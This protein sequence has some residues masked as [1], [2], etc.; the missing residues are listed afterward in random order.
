MT[1]MGRMK[2][3]EDEGVGAVVFDLDDTLYPERDFAFSGYDAVESWL[4]AETG[5]QGFAG[6]CRSVFEAGER[7]R[8][9]NRALALAGL[10]DDPGLIARMVDVYR[11][12][13]PRIRLAA[14]AA[15]WLARSA[16]P[17]GL[18]TD[19][20]PAMQRAKVRALGI[21]DRLRFAIFT[22]DWPQG[23]G[24]PHCRPFVEAERH[25]QR[26]GLRGRLVYVADNAAKDF[27]RP[28][29]RGWL[30]VQVTRPERI[31]RAPPRSQSF[32]AHAAI[33]D[34]DALDACLR[35]LSGR[36]ASAALASAG[37]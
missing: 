37:R 21:E 22:G 3:A 26:L 23:F 33:P 27:V 9:F 14:D 16:A 35:R 10:R 18:V 4:A 5:V 7:A 1:M 20:P 8:V 12:H 15:R 19:G 25:A 28:R 13:A 29:S 30:T 6:V 34:L 31:H 11:G 32:A 36:P 17:V 2:P 24:K